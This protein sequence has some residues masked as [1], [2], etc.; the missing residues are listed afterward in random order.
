[1]KLRFSKLDLEAAAHAGAWLLIGGVLLTGCGA[2]QTSA[3]PPPEAPPAAASSGV[4]PPAEVHESPPVSTPPPDVADDVRQ[5]EVQATLDAILRV[6]LAKNPDLAEADQ[7]ARAQRELAPSLGR[8]PDP[9]FEYQLW[10]Q[11]VSRP[12]ALDEAQAHMFGLSQTL[13]AL[14]TLDAREEVATAQARVASESRRAREQALIARVRRAYAEYYR[15]DREHRIHLEHA[16]LAH[17]TVE[18]TRAAYQVGQGTQQDVLRA[19]VAIGRMH[20]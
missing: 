5:L 17:A 11:P 10:G 15:A 8:L 14:G 18:L 1:M 19:A 4:A 16:Q 13:P 12:F 7:R 2:S 3:S 20:N 6:A 9:E